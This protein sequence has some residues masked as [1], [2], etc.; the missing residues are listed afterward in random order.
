M[1]PEPSTPS[2]PSTDNGA[3]VPPPVMPPSSRHLV[4]MFVVPGM[5]V[6]G[7]VVLGLV[8][9]GAFGYMLGFD[10]AQTA[11][12]Y[13]KRLSDPNTDIRWRAANDLVQVLKRDE[14]LASD[15]AL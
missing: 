4:Q 9:S 12:A 11:D 6:G 5:I 3:K 2:N 7:V 10:Q 1:Q 13:I 14:E 8:C 15:P